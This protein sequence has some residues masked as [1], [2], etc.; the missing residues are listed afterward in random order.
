MIKFKF[1]LNIKFENVIKRYNNNIF[2]VCVYIGWLVDWLW[3]W[4]FLTQF[5]QIQSFLSLFPIVNCMLFFH[6]SFIEQMMLQIVCL[7]D[8][9]ILTVIKMFS[10]EFML[11]IGIF[12]LQLYYIILIFPN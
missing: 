12:T 1:P 4:M 9:F 5:K 8:L 6:V 11:I 2:F 3:G 10:I 7:L